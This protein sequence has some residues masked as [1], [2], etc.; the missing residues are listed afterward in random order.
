MQLA[1]SAFVAILFVQSGLDKLF[2]WKSEKDF[3]TKHF[4][5]SILKGSV[6]LLMP[7]LTLAELATGILCAIGF[8]QV[9]LSGNGTIGT[10]GMLC[11]VVAL[12]MLFFGQRVAKDY[13]GSAVLVPYFLLC[14]AGLWVFI[15]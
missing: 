5:K 14:A 8:F 4:S 12:C 3:Y 9:L 11:G 1:F 13:A 10:I 6:P 7:V 15:M 2:N